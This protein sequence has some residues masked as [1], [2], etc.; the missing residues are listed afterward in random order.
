MA[1]ASDISAAELRR[2][3]RELR[4][5]QVRRRRLTALT[6]LVVIGAAALFGLTK[7]LSGSAGAA[8]VVLVPVR[9]AMPASPFHTALPEEIRAST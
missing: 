6:L 8:S 1:I 5:R 2:H 3:R 9:S 4:R 7:L